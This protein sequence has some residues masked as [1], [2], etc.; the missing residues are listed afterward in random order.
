MGKEE[1]DTDYW[2]Y[3]EVSLD[4]VV[5]PEFPRQGG[6][7]SQGGVTN[8]LFG[9]F[10]PPPKLHKIKNWTLRGVCIPGDP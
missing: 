9:Q 3:D 8:L 2:F 10:S 4:A 5:D 6:G 1:N 7:N